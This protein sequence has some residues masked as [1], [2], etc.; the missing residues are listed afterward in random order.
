MKYI[1]KTS[2]LFLLVILMGIGLTSCTNEN[3][4][5]L[6]V[7]PT[8]QFIK[9]Y[10]DF[11]TT[12]RQIL[13]SAK[14]GYK[15]GYFNQ[16]Q[17][18][19]YT[20]FYNAY[21]ADLRTDSALLLK[22]GV[23]MA[24]LVTI[25]KLMAVS[26]FNFISRVNV[27]DKQALAD[28]ITSATKLSAT[29]YSFSGFGA[30][31]GK[32]MQYDKTLYLSVISASSP[33]RDSATY[34]KAQVDRALNALT[35]ARTSFLN[36]VIPS[37]ITIYKQYCSNLINPQLALCYKV[38]VGFNILQYVPTAYNNYLNALRADSVLIANPT[39]TVDGLAGSMSILTGSTTQYYQKFLPNVCDKRV[40]NDSISS[41]I[42]LYNNTPYAP[43]PTVSGQVPTYARTN[44]NTAITSAT[45]TRDA[46]S[47]ID[48]QAAAAIFTL[49]NARNTFVALIKK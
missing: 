30:A 38:T 29:V 42:N 8:E 17:L 40:L 25:N 36:A 43:V 45:I 5:V 10:K 18:A 26:G 12:E 13:D 2:I 34:V 21:L 46:P 20:K 35:I 15:K 1:N 41:A 22:P 32:I 31:A 27:C 11:Y 7:K 23:T 14:I 39:T 6:N 24:E 4:V 28:S 19:N 44:F 33:S 9:Q 48:T 3:P 16:S 37:D 49:S 47:T